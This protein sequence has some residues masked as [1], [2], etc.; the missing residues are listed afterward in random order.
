MKTKP[1]DFLPISAKSALKKLGLGI[2]TARKLRSLSAVECSKR[3]RISRTTLSK[4]ESGDPNVALSS[5]ARI[6]VVLELEFLLG[7]FLSL[8]NDVLGQA[9]VDSVLP[10]RIVFKHPDDDF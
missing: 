2:K 4:L 7:E 1:S 8:S 9:M 3:A 5:L 6:F 10:K